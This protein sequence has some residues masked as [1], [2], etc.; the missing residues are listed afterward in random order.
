MPSPEQ[1]QTLYDLSDNELYKGAVA[2]LHRIV[3]ED[4]CM[5]LPASQVAGLLNI[6]NATSYAELSRFI[7]HQLERNWSESKKDIKTFYTELDKELT[8]IKKTYISRFQLSQNGK[9]VKEVNQETDELM[10]LLAHE[11]IQ[12]L[13]TENMVLLAAIVDQRAK[14][15]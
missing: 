5:P 3:D 15:R 6:A 1:L 14:R 7:R 13:M 2:F 11:F 9:S 8:T 12:H 10:A 4:E